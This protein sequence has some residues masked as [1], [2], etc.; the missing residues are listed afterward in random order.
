[1]NACLEI[2]L[3]PVSPEPERHDT[4]PQVINRW[5]WAMRADR[6]SS[7]PVQVTLVAV[8]GVS[9]FHLSGPLTIFE[10]AFDDAPPFAVRIADDPDD[11]ED[12]GRF[13]LRADGGLERSEE[14]GVGNEG[15]S[16]CRARGEPANYK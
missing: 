13:L 16:K 5:I 7:R 8:P 11:S 12:V 2:G 9:A 15:V 1:M 10:M 6:A 3:R 4:G 14:R